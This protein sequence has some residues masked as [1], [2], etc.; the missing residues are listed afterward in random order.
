MSIIS[1]FSLVDDASL[2]AVL[3]LEKYDGCGSR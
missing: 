1:S 3:A 2:P